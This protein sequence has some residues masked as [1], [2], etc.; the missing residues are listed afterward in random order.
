MP[1]VAGLD[2]GILHNNTQKFQG[3]HPG[4]AQTAAALNRPLEWPDD[5]TFFLF[6]KIPPSLPSTHVCGGPIPTAGARTY[7][8]IT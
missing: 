3:F 6:I 2:A 7:L 5:V 4:R 8:L 1:P